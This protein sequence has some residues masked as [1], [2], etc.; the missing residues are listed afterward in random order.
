V[1]AKKDPVVFEYLDVLAYL[2]EYY[3][4]RKSHD[5]GFS[6][7]NW[8]IELG[9][10][11]R[12][13]LRMMVIGKKKVTPKFIESFCAKRF[14]SAQERDY[15]EYLVK[16][17]QALGVKDRQAYGQKMIQI[18]RSQQPT[19]VIEDPKDF[20]S[21]PLLPRLFTLLSFEDLTPTAEVMAKLLGQSQ[22][23]VESALAILEKMNLVHR[24]EVEGVIVWKSL[25]S[26]F[27][28]PDD[29]GSLN[30]FKFHETSLRDAIEAFEKPRELRRYKSLLLPMDEEGIKNFHTILD[31][32]AAEQVARYRSETYQGKRMFQANF[33]IYPVAEPNT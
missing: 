15:F 7:E 13:F 10:N 18:I 5:R 31:Q 22:E 24:N 8:S 27:K 21:S 12:S 3:A 29:Y 19:H 14:S 9:F 16:Y 20:V 4:F 17:S 23:V 28:V 6:Y 33:N 1:A 2:Q 32:F 26:H 30:L 11:S 25:S